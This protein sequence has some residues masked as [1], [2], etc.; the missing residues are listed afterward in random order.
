MSHCV[1]RREFLRRAG[2]CGAG[3]LTGGAGLSFC[4]CGDGVEPREST[5]SRAKATHQRLGGLPDGPVAVVQSPRPLIYPTVGRPCDYD[6]ENNPCYPLVEEA[7]MLLNP[8]HVENPLG[9][10]VRPGDVVVIKPNWCT[11]YLFPIPITHPGLV[12]AVAE[13][14]ARA[15]AAKVRIVEAPMTMTHSATWF[16]GRSFLNMATWLQHLSR[17]H[18]ATVFEH[19]DGNADE[20]TW[21]LLADRSLLRDIPRDALRHDSGYVKDDMFYDVP[22]SRGFDP[23]KYEYGLYAVANSYLD[24][25]VFV[26]FPK[27]KTHAWTG[28]TIALKN[29][30]GLNLMSTLHRMPP[31]RAKEYLAGGNVSKGRENGMRD[32]PHFDGRYVDI[33]NLPEAAPTNDVLWRSLADLNRIIH[34]CDRRGR[35]Q[36][37]Q[38]RRYLNI[39][40]GI[41]GTENDG[42]ISDAR[43]CSRTIVAGADPVRVDAVCAR[44]MG[45]DPNKIPL[46]RNCGQLASGPSFGRLA[47]YEQS[48]VTPGTPGEMPQVHHYSQPIIWRTNEKANMDYLP[49]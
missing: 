12:H 8:Q 37:K 26:N 35:L 18:P 36:E 44:V 39:V 28:I 21:V 11:Q 7:L 31:Q 1:S 19:R 49:S 43:V 22:D 45:Y 10:V 27:M 32:V 13:L 5:I 20:F 29:L 40:D 46:I 3:L 38:Q 4:G 24:C 6:R 23:R 17:K 34:Y 48:V 14:A 9:N 41:I 2:R 42:P 47:D 30:M 25:D 16:Y 15:G 33:E